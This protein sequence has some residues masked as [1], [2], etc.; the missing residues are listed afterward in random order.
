MLGENLPV[1]IVTTVPAR[2]VF[3]SK[4][5]VRPVMRV[6]CRPALRRDAAVA[7]A[8]ALLFVEQR[9]QNVDP[10]VDSLVGTGGPAERTCRRG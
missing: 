3:R 6:Q 10:G 4:S 8:E 2:P 1:G 9:C 5:V 7:A